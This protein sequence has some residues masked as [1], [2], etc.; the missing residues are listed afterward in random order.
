MNKLE[1]QER[2]STLSDNDILDIVLDAEQEVIEAMEDVMDGHLNPLIIRG[3]AGVGKSQLVEEMTIRKNIISTDFIGSTFISPEEGP[4][5]PYHCDD[6]RTQPGALMRGADY[7]VWAFVAD[8]FAN[9]EQGAICL[10]DN[11]SILRDKNFC[12]LVLKATEQR[13]TNLISYPK[14]ITTHELQMYGVKSTFQVNTPIIILTNLDMQEQIR[15]ANQ[16]ERNGKAAKKDYISRWEALESRGKYIDIQMNSPRSIRVYCENKIK[17]VNM[18]TE[19]AWLEKT[20]GRSL[21]NDEQEQALKWV[22]HN[23]SKLKKPLDLRTY[24]KLA[25]IMIRRENWIKSAEVSFLHA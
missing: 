4:S 5:Y 3:P 9:Q 8:L 19:N 21:T 15:T 6:I 1:A 25:S 17:T 24:N 13:K 10:D 12:A 16:K 18:L 20:C 23:Q 14:A 2:E 22:R 11:D 7:A